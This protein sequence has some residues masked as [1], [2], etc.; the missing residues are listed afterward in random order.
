MNHVRFLGLAA[1]WQYEKVCWVIS[2]LHEV[3]SD[4]RSEFVAFYDRL[5]ELKM[6]EMES[7]S[8]LSEELRAEFQGRNRRFPLLHRNGRDYWV[9]PGSERLR[10][11][12]AAGFPRLGFYAGL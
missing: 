1:E 8:R 7:Y 10:R 9:S 2:N 5:F 6:D 4:Y 3:T 12:E 11:T